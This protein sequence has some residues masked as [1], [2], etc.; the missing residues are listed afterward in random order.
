MKTLWTPSHSRTSNA[1]ITSFISKIKEKHALSLESFSDVYRW[2]LDN[3]ELFWNE[4][5]DFCEIIGQRKG[6]VLS[7]ETKM[8]LS[9]F[10]PE[11]TLNFAANLLRASSTNKNTSIALSD[12]CEA[13]HKHAISYKEL[14][15]HVVYLRKKLQSAN[16]QPGD[17]VAGFVANT[18]LAVIAMLATTS[19]GAIWTSCSPDFGVPGVVDR[20]GQTAPKILVAID[21]YTFKNTIICCR[22]KVD[23]I[24]KAIPSITLVIKESEL[25]IFNQS[26]KFSQSD[27]KEEITSWEQFPFNHPLVIL[28]SSG[29]TGKPKCIVHRAGGVLLEHL[30]EL[31]LHVGLTASDTIFYQTTCGWMMWNWLISS[32]YFGSKIVL[33]D[34]SP[35]EK[36]GVLL[37]EIAEAEKISIFGTNAKWIS[38]IQKFEL[39]PKKLF[40]LTSLRTLLST[41]S[42]LSEENFNYIYKEVKKDLCLSSISGGTDILGCFALG[43]EMLPVISGELQTRSLGIAV[44]VWNEDQKSVINETGELVCTRPFPSQPLSF[45]GDSNFEKYKAAYF[46]GSDSVWYHGD[47][48]KLTER[49]SMIF[50]GRSDTVLNPGGVRIGTAEIY[51]Q[52]EKMP[53]I[54]ESIV[55]GRDFN[56]DVEICLFVKMKADYRCSDEYASQIRKL[57]RL[58]TTAFH[59]PKHIFQV[60]DIPKTK[61]GKLTELAV[62]DIINGRNVRNT[63]SL[64]DPSLLNE[65]Y[66]IRKTFL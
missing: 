66:E 38:I 36:R 11:S 9:S 46:S 42:P 19:L 24:Q 39:S 57:I 21:E 20:F 34:G 2:S 12:W 16:I 30:K 51:A 32:L 14:F 41:G 3:N 33:F 43:S 59:I 55:C 50:Y 54:E 35:I 13:Q 23:E 1:P 17:V 18:P 53:E 8:Y 52:V 58:N 37:F 4:V 31:S 49:G 48:V 15:E 62:S 64:Q 29:T 25:D 47:F 45:W 6:K 10:Y 61:N 60:S 27:I 65:F 63:E 44:E 40:P 22:K 26:K 28:Y 56:N 7:N 5:W